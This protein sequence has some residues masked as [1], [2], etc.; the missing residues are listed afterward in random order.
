MTWKPG[1]VGQGRKKPQVNITHL[2]RCKN[3]KQNIGMYQK[4]NKKKLSTDTCYK[5]DE[6]G[7]IMLSERC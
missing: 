4:D 7:N 2:Y 1:K 3:S 5:M 6:P